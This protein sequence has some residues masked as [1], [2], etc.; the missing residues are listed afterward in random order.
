MILRDAN[1]KELSRKPVTTDRFGT[2]SAD[3]E[4]PSSGLTG[5]FTITTNS[6][7]SGQ[8]SFKV[9][10]YKRPTFEVSLMTTRRS[11]Q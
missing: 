1:G 9:E 7:G 3:F 8:V 5:D 10:E 2:A 6:K 11:T 4:L